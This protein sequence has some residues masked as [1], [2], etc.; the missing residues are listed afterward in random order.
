MKFAKLIQ[1]TKGR[2][3]RTVFLAMLISNILILLLP[4]AIGMILYTKVEHVM[5][6][7]ASSSNYAML[8][9]LRQ[10]ADAR[11]REVEQLAQQ[12][13]FNPKLALL[14]NTDD[15][16]QQ[17]K[18]IE[19]IRDHLERYRLSTSGFIEDYYL[20]FA[21]SDTV[22]KP[23]MKTDSQ[24]FYDHYYR[25]PNMS[26]N[27]W[28]NDI[29]GT[30]H[31][32]AYLPAQLLQRELNVGGI[33]HAR[34]TNS[35]NVITFVQ[36]LPVREVTDISGSL[37]VLI[38]EKQ[39]M[40]MFASIQTANKS[41]I[42]I[43][44]EN[45]DLI[46]GTDPQLILSKDIMEH[47][48]VSDGS[49]VHAVNGEEM[50]VS[51][52]SS[53]QV[54]WK[55]I[56]I[57]PMNLYLERVN[58][59]K[60]T[61]YSLFLLCLLVG[62]IAAYLLAF[63][64]YSPIKQLV[65]AI[66]KN[67]KL[68]YDSPVRNEYTFIQETIEGAFVEEQNLRGLLFQQSPVIR[69]NFLLR[70][71]RGNF[72]QSKDFGSTLDFM[73]IRFVSEQFAVLLVHVD[74][75]TM[76][77]QDQSER[78]L[79][80]INFIISNVCTDLTAKLHHGYAVEVHRDR[81]AILINLSA[82]RKN[83]M[84]V[85]DIKHIASELKDIIENRFK[86]FITIA[87]SN[88]HAGI[89]QIGECYR[90]AMAAIDHKMVKGQ[91]SLIY[92][93]EIKKT[94]RHYTYP[95]ETEVQLMILVKRGDY[96]AVETVLNSIYEMNFLSQP[97]TPEFG[98]YL[99]FNL[100][101]TLLKIVN[102]T[103]TPYEKFI[104][105]DLEVIKSIMTCDTAKEMLF[106]TKNLFKT[107][108][109]LLHTERSDYSDQLS[110]EMEAFIAAHFTDQNLGLPMIANHFN[111]TPQY[112]STFFKKMTGQN[113]SDYITRIRVNHA[114]EILGNKHLT[115]AQVAR[116]VGY[117]NDIVFIRSFKKLE[118]MTPGKYREQQ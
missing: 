80:L 51:F 62:V 31:N 42:F 30:Y 16:D 5:V 82:D 9:Q 69:A 99:F 21:K 58:V 108:T 23:G 4:M 50:M 25:Y 26:Y 111:L 110:G 1:F 33:D 113:V 2:N 116:T 65:C 118:G 20:Y 96:T 70:L 52:T 97:I 34:I 83:E 37:V 102:S 101:S 90:E 13:T 92:Y 32:M 98:R 3:R 10:S 15:P 91:R 103:N 94:E 85:D 8:E 74:D 112:I 87:I 12:V 114:K 107:L 73:N 84:L 54:G 48:Q 89:E 100:V 41:S 45:N 28:R 106:K 68:P 55:Y 61:A 60:W 57:I 38:A 75:I 67:K 77:T 81:I 18:F 43:M 56:S 64:N 19:F 11:L 72:K 59:L 17:Y 71:I 53:K 6:E 95:I 40:D 24:T 22:L 115:N 44:N 88:V 39:F 29:L 104:D 36:S 27:N 66:Q 93:D 46:M 117:T 79:A 86:L 105:K 35:S 63:K 7:N 14:L 78:Q 109:E 76:F 49:F 47:F